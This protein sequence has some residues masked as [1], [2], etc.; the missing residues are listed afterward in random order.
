MENSYRAKRLLIY[1]FL[2][3]LTIL[4]ILPFW[5]VL[6]NA[7]RSAEQIQQGLSLWPGGNPIQLVRLNG[8]RLQCFQWI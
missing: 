6:V 1:V 3:L 7:T 5:V 2:V 8:Q 4:S